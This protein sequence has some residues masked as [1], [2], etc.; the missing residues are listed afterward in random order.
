MD[1][2][3][4]RQFTGSTQ[5]FRHSFNRAVIYTEG[6]QFLMEEGK[7]YWLVDA[8]ASHIGS[9]E[10]NKA[11]AQDDRIGLMHFWKL[12]V[13]PDQTATLKAVAD[14]GEQPFI[15]QQIPFTDFPLEEIDIWA[16]HN[17]NS[18]TLMLPSEY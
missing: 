17:G 2:S 16:Q 10:F 11:A 12:A 9:K 18:F 6:I 13:R 7:A 14:S 1:K 5:W 3:Q 15:E 8:I 4:L